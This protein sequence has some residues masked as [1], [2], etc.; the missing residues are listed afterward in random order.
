MRRLLPALVLLLLTAC[1]DPL[2]V[3]GGE[4]DGPSLY[5]GHCADCHGVD[6]RGTDS[7]PD[8]KWRTD[9]MTAADVAD[10]IVL[11]FGQMNALD[12]DDDEADAISGFLVE[13]LL[14]VP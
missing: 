3:D 6:A 12:L 7:G 1:G 5:L 14:Q 11:G 13:S 4:V 8:L 9:G 10:T 2:G